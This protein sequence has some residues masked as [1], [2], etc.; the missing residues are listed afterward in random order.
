MGQLQGLEQETPDLLSTCDRAQRSLVSV[1]P[2][3]CNP[4]KEE[5]EKGE[6]QVY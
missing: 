4:I 2:T 1:Y 3:L 5:R 6:R